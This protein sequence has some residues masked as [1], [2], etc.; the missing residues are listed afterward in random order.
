MQKRKKQKY[1]SNVFQVHMSIKLKARDELSERIGGRGAAA[2]T[3]LTPDKIF[4]VQHKPATRGRKMGEEQHGEGP[5][6]T[7]RRYRREVEG[8]PDTLALRCPIR[9]RAM[10]HDAPREFRTH[11][12]AIQG[13]SFPLKDLGP[14]KEL[15]FQGGFASVKR[16][17]S[18]SADDQWQSRLYSFNCW[19]Q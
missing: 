7:R 4:K 1:G 13:E 2:V 15:S 10:R 3:Q 14:R 18:R 9:T 11:Q 5:A 16:G 19:N 17:N 6:G 8:R 12:C